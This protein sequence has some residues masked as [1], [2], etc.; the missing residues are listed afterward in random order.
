MTLAAYVAEDGLLINGRRD[1]G[2]CE[3]SMTQYRGIPG[4]GMGVSGLGSR[5]KRGDCDLRRG[6]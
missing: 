6:N 2:S 4:T 3:V 5:N 1:P